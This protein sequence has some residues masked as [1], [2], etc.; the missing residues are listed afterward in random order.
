MKIL[1]GAAIILAT[2]AP[3]AAQVRY[4]PVR[5]LSGASYQG[6]E[7]VDPGRQP[8]HFAGPGDFTCLTETA[9]GRQVCHTY[10]EWRAIAA[11]IARRKAK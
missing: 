3:A 1:F 10:D 5:T 6:L 11:Q 8:D 2:I 7:G 4:A 9:T